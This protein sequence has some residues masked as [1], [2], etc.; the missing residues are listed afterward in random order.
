MK[1]THRIAAASGATVMGLALLTTTAG[2]QPSPAP[3]QPGFDVT[4]VCQQRVPK[5]ENRANKA[6]TRI[7]GSA[8]VRGSVASLRAR[9]GR[10]TDQAQKDWL[11]GK[12]DHRAQ[13]ADVIKKAQERLAAYKQK[14]CGGK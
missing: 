5:L 10:A 8:D 13:R 2:A 3:A 11:N 1:W 7:N 9:A 12:A 6:L 4:K 14:Y